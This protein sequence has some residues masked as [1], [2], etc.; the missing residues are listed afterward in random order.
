MSQGTEQNR[1]SNEDIRRSAGVEKD[2]LQCIKEKVWFDVRT[3]DEQ[4]Q[5]DAYRGSS[6]RIQRKEGEKEF[7]RKTWMCEMDEFVEGEWQ[8]RDRWIQL[9][10]AAEVLSICAIENC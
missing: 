10:N 6:I 9:L 3:S 1:T 4:I 2:T 5:T 8:D 7:S